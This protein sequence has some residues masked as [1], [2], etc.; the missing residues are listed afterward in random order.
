MRAS[1]LVGSGPILDSTGSGMDI[2]TMSVSEVETH[3]K[4]GED[5][6]GW[7]GRGHPQKDLGYIKIFFNATTMQYHPHSANI[8]IFSTCSIMCS[9]LSIHESYSELT[10]K[11]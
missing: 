4:T 6:P 8:L 3:L 1:G 7:N 2:S 5:L 9:N 11:Q 10:P